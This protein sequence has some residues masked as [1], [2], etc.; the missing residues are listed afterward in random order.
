MST[1]I[2]KKKT[3][4]DQHDIN[5]L[6]FASEDVSLFLHALTDGFGYESDA[7]DQTELHGQ[8]LKWDKDNTNRCAIIQKKM[9]TQIKRFRSRGTEEQIRSKLGYDHK[10]SILN[11]Q[12]CKQRHEPQKQTSEHWSDN[13]NQSVQSFH[14]SNKSI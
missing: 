5:E 13:I 9:T 10:R 12:E 4:T 2:F 14:Q 6:L 3:S 11:C 8:V 7:L 1:L